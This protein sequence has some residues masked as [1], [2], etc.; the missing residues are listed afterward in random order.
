MKAKVIAAPAC[1]EC[2]DM[3]AT[4]RLLALTG[5][6]LARVELDRIACGTDSPDWRDVM[7]ADYM[8]AAH[9]LLARVLP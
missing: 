1:D 3:Q 2:R 6:N 8:D 4:Y 5:L 7:A 9:D